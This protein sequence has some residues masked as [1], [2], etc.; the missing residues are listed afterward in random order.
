M[1]LSTSP[2][3]GSDYCQL[4]DPGSRFDTGRVVCASSPGRA[5]ERRGGTR[6]RSRV[7][8]TLASG[9]PVCP[10]YARPGAGLNRPWKAA[11]VKLSDRV[12]VEWIEGESMT[13]GEWDGFCISRPGG[14]HDWISGI[15]AR[16]CMGYGGK[17]MTIQRDVA[18]YFARQLRAARAQ[19]QADAE[20]YVAV[21]IA[22]EQLGAALGA[23]DGMAKAERCIINALSLSSDWGRGDCG[24]PSLA[25]AYDRVRRARN[26][27][28]H[29]GAMSRAVAAHAIHL[30][31][32]LEVALMK[33]ANTHAAQ[34]W[35]VPNPTVAH[36]W[37]T[38][39]QVRS[40]LLTGGFSALPIWWDEAWHLVRDVDVVAYLPRD[41]KGKKRIKD[42]ACVDG[43]G[44]LRIHRAPLVVGPNECV[45]ALKGTCWESGWPAL[46]VS[47]HDCACLV[48]ILTP[49]DLL[50]K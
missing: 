8:I 35:M 25:S 24:T 40:A 19:V 17:P 28:V 50:T 46:V 5:A 29:E 20:G 26:I 38:I 9:L 31:I 47:N 39:A 1:T 18:L 32:G 48:G 45:Q 23:K 4:L 30:T 15:F 42:V 16:P 21:A 27:A 7:T 36:P 14:L 2:V 22:I 41:P 10:P 11:V 12:Q 6:G 13:E 37:M 44:T 3:R 34:D 43:N 33:A 49:H